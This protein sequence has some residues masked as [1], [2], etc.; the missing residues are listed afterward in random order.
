MEII[1]SGLARDRYLENQAGK[2][3]IVAHSCTQK[4]ELGS[5]SEAS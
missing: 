4:P 2:L 1:Y 5:K 3:D